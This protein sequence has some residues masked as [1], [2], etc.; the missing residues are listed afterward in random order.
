MLVDFFHGN[1]H[2]NQIHVCLL[3]NS[4]QMHYQ[5]SHPDCRCIIWNLQIKF[6]FSTHT[7][8]CHWSQLTLLQIT[9]W[10][11]KW[12]CR[13]SFVWRWIWPAYH[14]MTTCYLSME[15]NCDRFCRYQLREISYLQEEFQIKWH[16]IVLLADSPTSVQVPDCVVKDIFLIFKLVMSSF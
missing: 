5:T 15:K 2:L 8:S 10:F 13:D 16:Y 14:F 3:F 11:L 1:L 7:S 12:I 9:H 6:L 4:P